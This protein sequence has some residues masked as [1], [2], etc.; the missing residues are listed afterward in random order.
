VPLAQY[1]PEYT[2]GEDANEGVE[3]ILGR[4]IELNRSGLTIYAQ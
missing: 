2:G 1:Y 4:F 3:F